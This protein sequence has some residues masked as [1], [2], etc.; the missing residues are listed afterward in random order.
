M[1]LD[2]E[3]E[4]NVELARPEESR[5]GVAAQDGKGLRITIPPT[6][7]AKEV[8]SPTRR[9]ALA[10]IDH[11]RPDSASPSEPPN[12]PLP[13]TPTSKSDSASRPTTSASDSPSKPAPTRPPPFRPQ[14]PLGMNP[15]TRPGTATSQAVGWK[16]PS[17]ILGTT[18]RLSYGSIASSKRPIK[19]GQG[20]YR[21]VELVPQPS[22]DSDD[23]LVSQTIIPCPTTAARC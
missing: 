7:P 20:K 11:T 4:L 22:D 6:P 19:Y 1:G 23:P 15:P 13:P 10:R 5:D 16:A 21:N 8:S 2:L 14:V 17:R 12:R 9:P 18:R 3:K